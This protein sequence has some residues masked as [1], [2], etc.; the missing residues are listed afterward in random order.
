M[1]NEIRENLLIGSV[2]H[3]PLFNFQNFI[4]HED[5]FQYSSNELE[6]THGFYGAQLA[7]KNHVNSLNSEN[8][9]VVLG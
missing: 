5:V 1:N 7:Q 3:F 8:M 4:V 6:R 9:Q 2:T